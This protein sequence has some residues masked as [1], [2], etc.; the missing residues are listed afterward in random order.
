MPALGAFDENIHASLDILKH[1]PCEEKERLRVIYNV[2]SEHYA[3][4]V[5]DVTVTRGK[6]SKQEYD[7]LQSL[8]DEA[9]NARVRAHLALERHKE[10][11]GC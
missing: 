7:R 4:A 11:H 1:V 8:V 6:T 9:S 3:T 2:A 5:N 10:K